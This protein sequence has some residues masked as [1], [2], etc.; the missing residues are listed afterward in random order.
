LPKT[1]ATYL[2]KI[3]TNR[4]LNVRSNSMNRLKPS[5]TIN[6][7]LVAIVM[8]LAVQAVGAQDKSLDE[9]DRE[10]DHFDAEARK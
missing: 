8:G 6:K 1:Y 3:S 5:I 4:I 2:L 9:N 10:A 7:L